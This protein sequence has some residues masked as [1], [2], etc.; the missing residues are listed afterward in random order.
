MASFTCEEAL[1][2]VFYDS[3]SEFSK[4]SD[5]SNDEGERI[6]FEENSSEMGHS[7]QYI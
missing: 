4:G 7:W 2:M 6:N 1:A 5:E 3:G